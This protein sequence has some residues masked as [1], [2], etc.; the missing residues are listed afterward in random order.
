MTRRGKC[1]TTD[2][3]AV[4]HSVEILF[5][6]APMVP[7]LVSNELVEAILNELKEPTE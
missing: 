1:P 2:L 7:Y 5:D 4:G 3:R 6:N